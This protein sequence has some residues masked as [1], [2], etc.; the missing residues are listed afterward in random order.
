MEIIEAIKGFFNKLLK[1]DLLL[2]ENKENIKE[3]EDNLTQNIKIEENP[4]KARLLKLQEE[5]SKGNIQEEDILK[6]DI[7][8]L[9]KLYDEQMKEI[10]N[11]IEEYKKETVEIIEE[12]KKA[13]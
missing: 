10:E 3:V 13:V 6:E 4:E 8:K 7:D 1:K 9:N 12:I 11:S 5:F 2:A